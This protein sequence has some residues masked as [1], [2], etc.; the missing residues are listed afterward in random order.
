MSREENV[1]VVKRAVAA[2]NDRDLERYLA[3]C[4]PDVRMAGKLSL[5]A[6]LTSER[7]T[8]RGKLSRERLAPTAPRLRG[9][10]ANSGTHERHGTFH[11]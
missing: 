2:V 11:H 5:S 10:R 4:T 7:G 3:C 1:E 8:T 9:L 6:A